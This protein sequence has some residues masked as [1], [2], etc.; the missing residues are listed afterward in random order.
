MNCFDVEA[1]LPAFV[2]GRPVITAGWS[3]DLRHVLG[4]IGLCSDA[5]GLGLAGER[6][7]GFPVP[8]VSKD[9]PGERCQTNRR[10]DERDFLY[11]YGHF[12]LHVWA[13]HALRAFRPGFAAGERVSAVLIAPEEDS[14]SAD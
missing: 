13:M 6:L 9:M 14:V 7:G 4:D 5:S 2:V 10:D 12:L 3:A 11:R 8:V 1:G